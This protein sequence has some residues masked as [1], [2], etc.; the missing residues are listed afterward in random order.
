MG[1]RWKTHYFD[2][3]M[4]NSYVTNYQ[5][6]ASCSQTRG[7]KLPKHGGLLGLDFDRWWNFSGHF[8]ITGVYHLGIKYRKPHMCR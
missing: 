4:F 2:W 1:K 7:R 5:R 3:A 8:L 6:V